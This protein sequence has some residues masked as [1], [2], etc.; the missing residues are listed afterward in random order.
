M[1]AAA[2]CEAAVQEAVDAHE[3][4]TSPEQQRVQW[5]LSLFRSG[6]YKAAKHAPTIRALCRDLADHADP[7]VRA[8]AAALREAV[9]DYRVNR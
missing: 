5:M 9:G 6:Q 8:A 2:A 4:A 1:N 7:D 3:A